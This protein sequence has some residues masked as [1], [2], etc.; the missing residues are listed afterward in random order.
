MNVVLLVSAVITMIV[1]LNNIISIEKKKP[2]SMGKE[3]KQTLHIMPW[4]L[5]LLGCLIL[6]PFEVWVLTGSS[7]DWDGVYIVAATFIMT[8]ILCYAYYYKRKQL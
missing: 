6:I 1:V 4:G 5:L 8:L 3:I 7:N 2:S